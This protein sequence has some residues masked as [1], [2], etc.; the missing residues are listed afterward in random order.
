MRV[1]RSWSRWSR[2]K[3]IVVLALT[4]V[5]SAILWLAG[6]LALRSA[7]PA[8]VAPWDSWWA[9]AGV[10]FAG[11]FFPIP[12]ATSAA[13]L[14]LRAHPALAAAGVVGAA[15]GATSG[16]AILLLAGSAMRERLEHRARKAD[17]RHRRL[18]RVSEKLVHHWTY[19][20]IAVLIAIPFVPRAIVLYAVSLVKLRMPLALAAVFAG[21]LVRYGLTAAGVR[22][23]LR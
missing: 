15:C 19:A 3:T 20:G 4:L 6:S 17:G 22:L 9:L 8:A 10:A 2:R 1:P 13:F 21:A 11:S 18:L 14:P 16:A 12:G 23:L 7:A 5:A